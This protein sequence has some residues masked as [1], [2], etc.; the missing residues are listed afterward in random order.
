MI[1]LQTEHLC[2]AYGHEEVL[3]DV[4]I[5][6][7]EGDYL[8][9]VGPNGSGKSTLMKLLLGLLESDHGEIRRS[10]SLS[11]IGYLPQHRQRREK[12]FPATVMEIV[13]T[14]LLATK[15][16]PK[17][18]TKE[19]KEAIKE[20][21]YSLDIGDLWNKSIAEIS[22][23][24]E[25]RVHLARCL[26]SKPKVIVLDEPT[27]ALDPRIRSEFY[28]MLSALNKQGVT[29]ILVTHDL[30]SVG[31]FTNKLIY[32]DKMVLFNGTY[33]DFSQSETMERYVGEEHWRHHHD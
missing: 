7:E 18:V 10:I 8:G 19:D 5:T 28:E 24:Q 21:L 16:P 23:G 22:G 2:Y 26:I 17:R 27:S 15:K 25:Q 4:N 1:Q 12:N 32:L 9:I 31:R 20:L 11:E 33:E 6:V 14:G 13:A 3:H 29:L 30:E